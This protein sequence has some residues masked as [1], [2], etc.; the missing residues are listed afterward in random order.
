MGVER[1]GQIVPEVLLDA[2]EF[3][4]GDRRRGFRCHGLGRHSFGRRQIE[5]DARG[6][7]GCGQRHLP[8]LQGNGDVAAGRLWRHDLG[9]KRRRRGGLWLPWRGLNPC[10]FRLARGHRLCRPA[11]A[12]IDPVRLGDREVPARLQHMIVQTGRGRMHRMIQP[13][14]AI[15]HD[16]DGKG[17]SRHQ[18][19]RAELFEARHVSWE[20]P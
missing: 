7:S 2:S 4:R 6:R 20:S 11:H 8:W 18:I 10:E 12:V 9:P 16:R 5:R 13:R 15:K 14:M 19:D 1:V 3:G 17:R